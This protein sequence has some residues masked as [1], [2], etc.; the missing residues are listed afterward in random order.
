VGYL[1]TSVCGGLT[2][3]IGRVAFSLRRLAVG[4]RV[5]GLRLC[6]IAAFATRGSLI[7]KTLSVNAIVCQFFYGLATTAK[8]ANKAAQLEARIRHFRSK[9]VYLEP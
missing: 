3:C 2:L 1:E 9:L 4:E 5:T 7:T 6:L 8:R